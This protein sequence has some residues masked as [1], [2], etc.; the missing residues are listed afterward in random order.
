V[1]S[2][3]CFATITPLGSAFL[4]TSLPCRF[5][6]ERRIV[7]TTRIHIPTARK[8]G[9]PYEEP[10]VV[11][12]GRRW[13]MGGYNLPANPWR[14]PYTVKRYGREQAVALYR[15]YILNSEE[16]LS[17]L[18]E[19]EGRTLGCWCKLDERCHGD[20]LMELLETRESPVSPTPKP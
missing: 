3:L 15:E 13:T 16:L 4:T 1:V 9:E 14:N 8:N 2:T 19:L 5:E 6:S 20:V 12:I 17:R 10:H 7:S 18:D 11:Y